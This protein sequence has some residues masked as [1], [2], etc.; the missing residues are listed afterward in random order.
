MKTRVPA[1][2]LMFALGYAS[3]SSLNAQRFISAQM[4][5]TSIPPGQVVTADFNGDGFADVAFGSGLVELAGP[6]HS[7][8]VSQQL[9]GID[10]AYPAVGDFNADGVVD[11]AFAIPANSRI[12]IAIFEGNGDGTFTPGATYSGIN[13]FP[14]ALAAAD[15]NGDG[16]LDLVLSNG[17]IQVLLGRGDGNFSAPTLYPVGDGIAYGIAIGDLNGDGQLDVV[18]ATS[19]GFTGNVAVLLG[20][21]NGSLQ[22]PVTYDVAQP[23]Y[24]VA[25]SDVNHDGIADVAEAG[26]LGSVAVLLGNGDGT[27]KTEQTLSTYDRLRTSMRTVTRT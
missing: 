5:P 23:A 27:L 10:K 16:S 24:A 8:T 7:F 21:G 25:V 11:L 3:A 15:L 6:Q 17:G 22:S 1:A 20:N 2:L 14:E 4:V 9:A 26:Y 12:T 19:N 18:A 13:G